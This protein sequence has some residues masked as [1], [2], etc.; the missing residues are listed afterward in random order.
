MLDYLVQDSPLYN[1]GGSQ[2]HDQEE[3]RLPGMVLQYPSLVTNSEDGHNQDEEIDY[4]RLRFGSIRP[5]SSLSSFKR[6]GG[7]TAPSAP[8][9]ANLLGYGSNT[10]RSRVSRESRGSFRLWAQ[11]SLFMHA[12]VRF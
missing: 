5:L 8:P 6:A 11:V 10:E 9:S 2:G 12:C 7:V 1:A 4:L 3:Q